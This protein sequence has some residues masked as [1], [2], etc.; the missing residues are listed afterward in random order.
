M[1][2]YF[3]HDHHRLLLISSRQHKSTVKINKVRQD[4][5]RIEEIFAIKKI[6]YQ[7]IDVAADEKEKEKMQ[8]ISGKN[9]IPQIF[10]NDTFI[11]L[12]EQ[13]DEANEF[14]ELDIF[15]GIKSQ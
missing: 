8:K 14:G 11:G 10:N 1:I 9:V 13:L 15:L 3:S 2:Q 12:A 6:Q 5:S 4:T 7:K